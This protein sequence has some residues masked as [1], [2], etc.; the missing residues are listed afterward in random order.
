M[1]VVRQPIAE[2]GIELER[3]E[4][5]PVTVTCVPDMANVAWPAQSIFGELSA[6]DL[7]RAEKDA[8]AGTVDA[9]GGTVRLSFNC[10]VIETPDYI[11][12]IDGGIG[13][14]KERPHRPAWHRRETLFLDTLKAIGI[15]AEDV[16]IVINT[17][18]HADHVGWNTRREGETW[19]PTFPNARYVVSE[20]ELSHW[21]AVHAAQ[22][23]AL[24]GAFAD[25]VLPIIETVGFEAVASDA[26]VAVGLK[27]HPAPGHSPGMVA[28]ALST[29]DGE[30]LFL[31]DAI[32]HP[33]Q[34]SD[35]DIVCEDP[36]LART[37]RLALLMQAVGGDVVLAPY[38]FP[39]PVFGRLKAEAASF[40][41][42]PLDIEATGHPQTT[43]RAECADQRRTKA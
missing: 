28:V 14:G 26:Q 24:H 23:D 19:R 12:V 2:L 25:S 27:L 38:H 41:F 31:A 30:V 39:A 5:G 17:H 9:A 7:E 6:S 40:R 16:D 34:L 13:D 35:N 22:P 36:E 42:V 37:T 3:L 43:R 33:L 18:L 11:A 20:T 32:H 21:T 4:S 1:K 29:A 10:Y 15:A 8:P